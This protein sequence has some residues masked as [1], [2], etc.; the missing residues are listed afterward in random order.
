M[1]KEFGTWCGKLQNVVDQQL[2]ERERNKDIETEQLDRQS[3]KQFG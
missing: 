3:G 2:K 1:A